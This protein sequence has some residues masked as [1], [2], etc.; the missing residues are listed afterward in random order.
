METIVGNAIQR[1]QDCQ[2]KT[3]VIARGHGSFAVIGPDVYMKWLEQCRVTTTIKERYGL[4]SAFDYLVPEK[5]LDFA[6]AAE[7][8]PELARQL[9]RFVSEVRRIFQADEIRFH[10][11]RV[12]H[13]HEAQELVSHDEEIFDEDEVFCD[14]PEISAARARSFML[15]KQLLLAPQLGTS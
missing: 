14:D 5:L 15:I 11:A 3:I 6:R 13:E 2:R 10:L 9:P 8:E 12:E 4:K 7:R 1:L